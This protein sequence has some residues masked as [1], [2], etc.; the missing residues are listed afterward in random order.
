MT[1]DRSWKW[2]SLQLAFLPFAS[3]ITGHLCRGKASCM[4]EHSSAAPVTYHP[5]SPQN[6]FPSLFIT[7]VIFAGSIESGYGF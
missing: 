4:L 5:S 3:T 2:N 6:I 1:E 7:L